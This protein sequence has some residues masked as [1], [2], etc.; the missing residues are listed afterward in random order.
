MHHLAAGALRRQR[1]KARDGA[2]LANK[3]AIEWQAALVNAVEV[4]RRRKLHSRLRLALRVLCFCTRLRGKRNKT[5][6]NIGKDLF[7]RQ[8][9]RAAT[10][11]AECEPEAAWAES[12][13]ASPRPHAAAAGTGGC[14]V[15]DEVWVCKHAPA[16]MS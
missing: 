16:A 2:H 6:A 10:R 15:C 5:R 13:V 14:A 1:C 11:K 7:L 9:R 12:G 8:A 4:P 3:D